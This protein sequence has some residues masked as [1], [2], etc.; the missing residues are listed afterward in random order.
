MRVESKRIRNPARRLKRMPACALGAA[1]LR[2]SALFCRPPFLS[3]SYQ[4]SMPAGPNIEIIRVHEQAAKP[5]TLF[6]CGPLTLINL[7]TERVMSKRAAL[8][9]RF[10]RYAA[11]PTQSNPKAGVVPSA[12]GERILADMLAQ[13]LAELGLTDVA[14]SEHAVVTAR[15]AARGADNAPK[16]G[17]IIIWIPSTSGSRPKSG[18]RSSATI[19][20]ATFCRTKRK[21][22][23]SALPSTRN[24]SAT[25]ATTS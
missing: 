24:S 15:L 12:P 6:Q 22:S 2:L 13:E 8:L 4:G 25:K 17:W 20:V 21:T 19:P 10:M 18:R 23:G 11:V 14:V 1:G 5:A 3:A 9:E 16:I 7:P